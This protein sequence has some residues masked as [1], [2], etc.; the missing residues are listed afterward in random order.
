MF[1]IKTFS[2]VVAVAKTF[3]R[4]ALD[5]AVANSTLNQEANTLIR[6]CIQWASSSA[7]QV[8]SFNDGNNHYEIEAIFSREKI[9][10]IFITSL[11]DI[12]IVRS[13]LGSY[14]LPARQALQ[15]GEINVTSLGKILSVVAQRNDAAVSLGL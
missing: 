15:R 9:A 11:E 1:S 7:I 10:G 8:E 5:H 3:G 2:D 13:G 12:E 14:R 6:D 4:P